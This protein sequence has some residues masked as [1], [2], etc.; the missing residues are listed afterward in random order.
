MVLSLQLSY[1][2]KVFPE[3][4]DSYQSKGFEVLETKEKL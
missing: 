1:D 4:Y 3:W 2:K